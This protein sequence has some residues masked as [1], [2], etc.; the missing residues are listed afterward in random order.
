MFRFFQRS[1]VVADMWNWFEDKL[2]RA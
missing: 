2:V 1:L